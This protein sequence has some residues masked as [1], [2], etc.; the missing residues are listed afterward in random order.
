MQLHTLC[1]LIPAPCNAPWQRR[2]SAAVQS[3]A[4][5][6][7][8]RAGRPA[9]RSRGRWRGRYRPAVRLGQ[10]R[11]PHGRRVTSRDL[12]AGRREMPAQSSPPAFPTRLRQRQRRGGTL[13][14]QRAARLRRRPRT[15]SRLASRSTG[16]LWLAHWSGRADLSYAASDGMI[17]HLPAAFGNIARLQ[18]VLLRPADAVSPHHAFPSIDALDACDS[19]ILV[20]P[21]SMPMPMRA[22]P[23]PAICRAL[24]T[25]I[26]PDRLRN[27]CTP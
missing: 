16:V 19:R 15:F 3:P 4:A 6:S 17:M 10:G 8:S 22:P 12:H 13:R 11:K 25:F 7:M 20:A 18:A 26:C 21:G 5:R 24:N 1:H 27:S 2:W 14:T 9:S 23:L